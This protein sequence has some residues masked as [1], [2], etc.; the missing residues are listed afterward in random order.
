MKKI[1]LAL[2]LSASSVFAYAGACD[3]LYPHGKEIILPHTQ[4][5]C[6]SFYVVRYDYQLK[7][8]VIVSEALHAHHASVKRTDNFAPDARLLISQRA[9]LTDYRNSGYDKGHM[10]PA[11]DAS[12]V[13]QMSE[14]FLLSNM[15]PQL[16][17]VN[18]GTWRELEEYVRS[19]VDRQTGT[20]YV[21]TGAV[22]NSVKTETIGKN[23]IPVP[24]GYYKVIYLSSGREAYYV[25][26]T[27]GSAVKET[28]IEDL[29]TY[30]GLK[31]PK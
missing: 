1:F 22:Y 27:P 10:A 7:G 30:S 19:T 25:H 14:T 24:V 18:R 23:K 13:K 8:V 9:E 21:L 26:N 31:F 6:N 20:V 17:E 29:E 3:N 15:T 5:L 16:P 12:T 2:V 11:A 4:E 28:T